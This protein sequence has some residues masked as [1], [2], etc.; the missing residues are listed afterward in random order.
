[1]R[2]VGWACVACFSMLINYLHLNLQYGSVISFYRCNS[3]R[4]QLIRTRVRI[5]RFSNC[6]TS[7][8]LTVYLLGICITILLNEDNTLSK[9][10]HNSSNYAHTSSLVMFYCCVLPPNSVIIRRSYLQLSTI[11][12]TTF[13]NAFLS[14]KKVH[15]LKRHLSVF[16]RIQLIMNQHWFR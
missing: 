5:S 14:M 9:G 3:H 2:I 16:L 12:Q 10:M 13:S 4:N 8:Y 1:M 6:K 15:R 11:L 7:R